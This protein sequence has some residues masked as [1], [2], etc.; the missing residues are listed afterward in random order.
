MA[1]AR[2][3]L[4]LYPELGNGICLF[5]SEVEVLSGLMFHHETQ[6]LYLVLGVCNEFGLSGAQQACVFVTVQAGLVGSHQLVSAVH[7][8]AH[9]AV[10]FQKFDFASLMGAVKI[11]GQSAVIV[12]EIAEVQ[13]D[14]VNF[15]LI[16]ESDSAYLA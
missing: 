6:R 10:F 13:G 3:L 9:A 8:E 4:H 14:Y 1:F 11:Q 7:L 12:E 2:K 5:G 15:S 16:V